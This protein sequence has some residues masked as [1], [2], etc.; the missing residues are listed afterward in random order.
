MFHT[1]D[2]FKTDSVELNAFRSSL[3]AMC[4]VFS[5]ICKCNETVTDI[6]WGMHNVRESGTILNDLK[7][8]MVKSPGP[9]PRAEYSLISE[10]VD[11]ESVER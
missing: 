4:E 10:S 2:R 7:N 5:S 11:L 1:Q 3:D 8:V 6:L 9:F